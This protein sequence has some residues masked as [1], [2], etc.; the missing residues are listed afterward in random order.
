MKKEKRDILNKLSEKC[1]NK[2]YSNYTEHDWPAHTV[3]DA[4]INQTC[5][6]HKKLN[7]K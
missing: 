3:Y 4:C 5:I 1:C 6:C 7:E 2:C